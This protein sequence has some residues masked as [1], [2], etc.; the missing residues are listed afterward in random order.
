[1]A[2]VELLESNNARNLLQST[3]MG[4]VCNEIS[5]EDNDRKFVK[6]GIET[7]FTITL[8]IKGKRSLME[9]LQLFIKADILDGD[10]M[11]HS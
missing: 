3:M 7:F 4:E 2:F 10:N 11:Y 6:K 8:D 9:A 5:A 1:M